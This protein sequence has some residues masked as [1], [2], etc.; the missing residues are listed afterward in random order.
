MIRYVFT[1]PGGST[2][3]QIREW[4]RW[5]KETGNDRRWRDLVVSEGVKVTDLRQ[6]ASDRSRIPAIVRRARARAR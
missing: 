1:L 6:Q 3:E 4:S 5:L 2:Q